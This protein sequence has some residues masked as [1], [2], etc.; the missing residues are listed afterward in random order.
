MPITRH[1]SPGLLRAFL[2]LPPYRFEGEQVALE[3]LAHGTGQVTRVMVPH[4]L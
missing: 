4:D 3:F 1:T 2:G